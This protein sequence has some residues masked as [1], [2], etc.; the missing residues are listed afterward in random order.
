MIKNLYNRSR[1]RR[2]SSESSIEDL[3]KSRNLKETTEFFISRKRRGKDRNLRQRKET[4][5]KLNDLELARVLPLSE[6]GIIARSWNSVTF[7]RKNIKGMFGVQGD[8]VTA[9]QTI[10]YSFKNQLK[11]RRIENAGEILDEIY[12]RFKKLPGYTKRN[13]LLDSNIKEHED[14]LDSLKDREKNITEIQKEVKKK[15]EQVKKARKEKPEISFA[16]G[17][18]RGEQLELQR[19]LVLYMHQIANFRNQ[20]PLSAVKTNSGGHGEVWGY[21]ALDAFPNLHTLPDAQDSIPHLH[22]ELLE[23]TSDAYKNSDQDLKRI[24]L[25]SSVIIDTKATNDALREIE[26]LRDSKADFPGMT[27][28]LDKDIENIAEQHVKSIRIAYPEVDKYLG[29][30]AREKEL[31]D[32]IEQIISTPLEKP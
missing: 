29:Q 13:D 23:E 24:A 25:G 28:D 11:R 18:I 2:R 4:I 14:I 17:H 12:D 32:I 8:H 3:D 19:E 16:P 6:K 10:A 20:I 30:G 31:V 26:S 22:G 15:S 27:G 5:S 7:H 21:S 1:K 9:I